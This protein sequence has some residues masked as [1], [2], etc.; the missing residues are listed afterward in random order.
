MFYVETGGV[1]LIS[2]RPFICAAVK[3][4]FFLSIE[5]S[6]ILCSPRVTGSKLSQDMPSAV[7]FVLSRFTVCLYC[8]PYDAYYNYVT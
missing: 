3:A 6:H 5:P 4:T 8:M 7:T 2:S 1:C